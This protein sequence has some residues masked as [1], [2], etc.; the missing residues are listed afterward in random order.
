MAS[1]KDAAGFDLTVDFNRVNLALAKRQNMLASLM[2][3][4]SVAKQPESSV[5]EEVSDDFT[6]EPELCVRL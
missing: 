6:A 1:S 3:L 2:G 5:P 4:S